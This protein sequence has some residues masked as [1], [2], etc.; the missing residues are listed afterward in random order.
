MTRLLIVGVDQPGH[1]ARFLAEAASSL[2]FQ[3]SILDSGLAMG[4]PRWFQSLAWRLDHYPLALHRFA[5]RVLQQVEEL[6]PDVLIATGQ[7]PLS[8][9]C[10]RT[11]RGLGLSVLNYSTDDPWNPCHRSRWFLR[12]IPS[13]T[14]IFS[15]RQAALSDFRDAGAASVQWLPFGY[16][17]THHFRDPGPALGP[18]LAAVTLAGGADAARLALLSPLIEAG[19]PLAL[20]GG[21]WDRDPRTRPF[22]NGFADSDQL[23]RLLSNTPCALALVRRANRDGHAMRS[24]EVAAMGAPVLAEDTPEHRQIYGAEGHAVLYFQDAQSL[25]AKARQLLRHPSEGRHMGDRLQHCILKG[26]HT[27][28]DRLKTMLATC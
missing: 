26:H 14:A 9:S 16:S 17:P 5:R 24:F 15:T 18:E 4:Q 19:V 7:A 28:A 21:Y 1:I 13:Y 6:Q 25:I 10:M 20:W 8:A 3:A 12:A 22:A 27:Y 2:G 11:L 23:R